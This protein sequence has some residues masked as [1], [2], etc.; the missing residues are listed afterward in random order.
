MSDPESASDPKGGEAGR[1]TQKAA[2]RIGEALLRR[3]EHLALAESATGGG[4][5]DRLTDVAGASD[6]LRGAVVA[7]TV[8][9]K[10]SLLGVDRALIE[11]EGAVSAAC[12]EAM[13]RGVLVR[14]GTTWSLAT[15]GFAGPTGGTADEPVGALYVAVACA[16]GCGP[17]DAKVR[18]RRRV[19]EDAA[20]VG[21]AATKDR[22]AELALE[23][24]LDALDAVDEAT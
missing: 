8:E 7:Y 3:G 20:D 19:V 16:A 4:V 11:R 17:A 1:G 24:L 10:T 13:A 22:M 5:C 23:E 15:T 9:A 12:A 14:A 6:W 2:T 21:R 18:V